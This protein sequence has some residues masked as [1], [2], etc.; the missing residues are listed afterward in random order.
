MIFDDDNNLGLDPVY[1]GIGVARRL[2]ELDQYR[3]ADKILEE[4][5]SYLEDKNVENDG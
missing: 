2:M 1:A 3:E 4:I 5:Q